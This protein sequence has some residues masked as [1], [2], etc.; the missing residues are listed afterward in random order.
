MPRRRRSG[1][2]CE[3]AGIFLTG[4]WLLL[5]TPSVAEGADVDDRGVSRLTIV[6]DSACPS[7]Q[8]VASA[9][10]TLNA[11]EA[12]PTGTVRI[13]AADDTLVVDLGVTTI[14]PERS[15]REIHVTPDCDERA[16]TVAL[17]IA[18]WTGELTSDAASAPV[19]PRRMVEPQR[20]IAPRP[21]TAAPQPRPATPSAREIGAGVLLS[22]SGGLAPGLSVDFVQ[23]KNPGGLGW[24]A[25]LSLPM[26]RDRSAVGGTTRWTRLTA[27]VALNASTTLGRYTLSAA[28]GVVGAYTLTSGQGYPIERSAQ[29]L[30]GGLA[31]GLR[32]GMAWRRLRIW[33]EVE[34]YRY[35][36]PQTILVYSTSGDAMGSA[37]LPSSDVR[38]A[39]GL[40]YPF[41]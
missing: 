14:G 36:F 3:R 22:S 16:T 13:Q 34:A 28:A 21:V 10:A 39:L 8:A 12:W 25:K 9:L 19:L 40:A 32:A 33:T 38:W 31:A 29:A 18:T 6:S 2:T 27:D 17:V 26:Q 7:Q 11:P 37:S 1:L 20:E 35:V 23:T 24:Q 4:A 15:H 41:R 30:T 5:S